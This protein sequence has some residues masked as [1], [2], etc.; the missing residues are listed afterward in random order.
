M[1]RML[2]ERLT[3][4]ESG[5]SLIEYALVAAL[6]ALGATTGMKRVASGVITAYNVISNDLT[7]AISQSANSAP[8]NAV[9]QSVTAP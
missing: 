6:I 7:G 8:V 9:F 4:D 3:C 5:D 1:N 2:L